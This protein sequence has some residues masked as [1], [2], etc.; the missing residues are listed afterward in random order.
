M[1]AERDFSLRSGERQ[2]GRTIEEIRCDHKERY[3]TVIDRLKADGISPQS[4][5]DIFCGVGYGSYMFSQA[6]PDCLIDAYDGSSDAILH[7]KAN[8]NQRGKIDFRQGLW[9]F[10]LEKK[11]DV[12]LSIESI[13]HVEDDK[14]FLKD[15]FHAL[16]D[17]G[18][19]FLSFPNQYVM[20]LV[21]TKH[22]FHFR[23]Y[24][25]DEAFDLV[26][27]VGFGLVDWYGQ[28]LCYSDGKLID[29]DM[30]YCR[31]YFCGDMNMF[32]LS[33]SAETGAFSFADTAKVAEANSNY[34]RE[35][36]IRHRNSCKV[37]GDLK[38]KISDVDSFEKKNCN[39]K[40]SILKT[41]IHRLCQ[42]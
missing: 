12:I 35:S 5:L 29:R 22:K 19:L 28:K 26:S 17:N 36:E 9:P 23:H 3:Q 32:M 14:Q 13:E 25:L 24:L 42:R 15:L 7:A 37:I 40:Q 4:A 30:M 6:F 20:P 39:K 16:T 21:K 8:F 41:I 2:I 10:L 1:A 11:Y 27:Q 31:Q 34:F 38:K 33:N 18:L